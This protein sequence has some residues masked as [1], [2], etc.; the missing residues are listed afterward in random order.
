MV[1]RVELFKKKDWVLQ[2]EEARSSAKEAY[3]VDRR[4]RS[5]LH[6][7]E[8]S[9]ARQALCSQARAP[10]TSATLNELRDLSDHPDCLRPSH[11]RSVVSGHTT[12][13]SLTGKSARATSVQCSEVQQQGSQAT[14]TNT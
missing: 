4:L 11:L 9:R 5:F 8:V 13:F 2:L 6:Q 1:R 3:T 7:G 12:N 10:G 14:P